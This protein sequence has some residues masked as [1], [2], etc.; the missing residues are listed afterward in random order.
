MLGLRAAVRPHRLSPVALAVLVIEGAAAAKARLPNRELG[1]PAF[2]ALSVGTRQRRANQA[3]MHRPVVIGARCLGRQIRLARRRRRE[4]ER[5]AGRRLGRGHLIR[6]GAVG[7]EPIEP[8]GGRRHSRGG[9]LAPLRRHFRVL[10]LVIGLARRAPRLLHLVV[11]H[12]DD[13][14]VG[15]AALAR[16]VVVQDVTEPNPALLHLPV[17]PSQFRT[18]RSDV[19]ASRISV[20]G[21]S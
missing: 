1:F 21:L 13:S 2:G 11:N 14:V 3:A 16:T 20:G 12:G 7:F 4:V 10:V 5:L 8:H 15:D 19:A 18:G 9:A 17:R 6:S